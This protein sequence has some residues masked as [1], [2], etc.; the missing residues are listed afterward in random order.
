[1][2]LIARTLISAPTA[3]HKRCT[4]RLARV[5]VEAGRTETTA[6]HRITRRPITAHTFFGAV[7]S[8]VALIAWPIT[9][10]TLPALATEA[11]PCLGGT[12]GPIHTLTLILTVL[13]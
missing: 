4:T 7:R 3:I 8:V 11:L 5:S 2:I 6:R 9:E 12:L 10:L 13:S 1:M